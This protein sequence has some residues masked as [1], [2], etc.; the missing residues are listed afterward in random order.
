[1]FPLFMCPGEADGGYI[2]LRRLFIPG[3]ALA[4]SGGIAKLQIAASLSPCKLNLKFGP[5]PSPPKKYDL[6]DM[7]M[8]CSKWVGLEVEIRVG[9]LW[10]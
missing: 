6:T 4:S 1:M 7:P 10:S 3:P 5:C 9:V 2:D 8:K